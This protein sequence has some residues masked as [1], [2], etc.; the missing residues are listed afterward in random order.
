MALCEHSFIPDQ[1]SALLSALFYTC[2]FSEIQFNSGFCPHFLHFIAPLHGKRAMKI[3]HEFHSHKSFHAKNK[4][5]HNV[6]NGNEYQHLF[7]V[8]L[9][10]QFTIY[11]GRYS[12]NFSPLNWF[13]KPLHRWMGKAEYSMRKAVALFVGI[14]FKNTT[15]RTV[16]HF[17]NIKAVIYRLK[18]VD[19]KVRMSTKRTSAAMFIYSTHFRLL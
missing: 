13:T 6:A 3:S 5:M 2:L 19:F 18:N 11:C 8:R 1:M 7:T 10:S 9:S 15:I 4:Q 16:T 12:S 17:T 14:Y